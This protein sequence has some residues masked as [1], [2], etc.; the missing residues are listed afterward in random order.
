LKRTLK[1]TLCVLLAAGIAGC[2][3]LGLALLN[4]ASPR[5]RIETALAYAPGHRGLLDVYLPAATGA[6]P[7]PLVVFWY[8]GGFVRGERA[9]YRFVGAALASR[10]LVTVVPD[11]RL[12]PDAGFQE[13][14]QDAAQA[15]AKAQ[16]EAVRWGADSC[17]LI[18]IGHSA[19]AYIA[20]ML[21]LEPRYLRE[22]GVDPLCVR[23]W[24]GLSGPYDIEPDTPTLNAIFTARA[25]PDQFK[26]VRRVSAAAPPALLVHGEADQTV[27][28]LHS[29]RMYEALR[30]QRAIVELVSYPDR[31]HV[32]TVLALSRPGQFRI[33]ELQDRIATFVTT[34]ARP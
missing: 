28:P 10:G 15:V 5:V 2:Q 11:Y 13:F 14:L 16:R 7:R 9:D 1:T 17:Q 6:A 29:E 25:S 32:D 21:A 27:L 19:G 3:T 30:S 34:H 22:A 26:P 12:H 31:K 18:L 4:A 23:G 8:G 33:P 24:V 20:S